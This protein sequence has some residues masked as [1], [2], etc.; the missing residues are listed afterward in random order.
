MRPE[1]SGLGWGEDDSRAF[2]A[3]GAAF[4]PD[5]EAQ[6]RTLCALIPDPRTPFD[7]LDLGCGEGLL[8][9]AILESFPG[10]TV[11]AFDGSPAMLE[12]AR[13]RLT[14]F[15]R[16]ALAQ[17]FDLASSDWRFPPFAAHAVVA[18][19]VIHHL[20]AEGK[21]QLFRDVHAILAPGGA[22]LI[23]DLVEPAS[24]VG[25]KYAAD[26]W[27]SAVRQR[28]L[29]LAGDLSAYERFAEEA[30]NYFRHPD[31]ADT[32]STLVEQLDWLREAGFQRADVFWMKAGHAIFGGFRAG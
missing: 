5:R 28:S 30:W 7:V 25:H 13:E 27:D 26:A 19:L 32:P 9:E 18:S 29:A 23:A 21:R 6:I 24:A 3:H 8:S 15:R 4:V 14:P 1:G 2:L 12:K 22:F 10:A 11:H 17:P 16:R 31:P 20:D